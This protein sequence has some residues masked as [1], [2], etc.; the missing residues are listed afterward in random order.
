MVRK[1]DSRMDSVTL[2]YGLLQPWYGSMLPR[3]VIQDQNGLI[4]GTS[5]SCIDLPKVHYKHRRVVEMARDD[6]ALP[7]HAELAAVF[8]T[9]VDTGHEISLFYSRRCAS[10]H[11]APVA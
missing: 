8:C 5:S 11:A 1:L 2:V 4:R 10:F 9:T 3:D 6:V 7:V